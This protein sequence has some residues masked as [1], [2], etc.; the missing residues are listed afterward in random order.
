MRRSG[1]TL[2]ELMV[3]IT[4]SGIVLLGARAL[5]ES[6]AESVDR[7]RDQVM[8]A[9][10]DANAERLLRS[11]VGRIEVGTEQS[12]EFAGDEQHATFTTWCTMPAG[13]QERCDAALAIE[14]DSA[15]SLQLVARLATGEVIV[16]Q[17]GFS[18]GA[19]R[20]LNDPIGGGIWFRIWGHGITAPLAIGIITD[21]DTAIVRIGDRA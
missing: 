19:L 6:L 15:K 13:W 2:V 10:R 7:L 18:T 20:Y 8:V 1:L 11:I 9:E 12:H 14:S 5:W 21:G 16:L 17:R 4:I 3:A